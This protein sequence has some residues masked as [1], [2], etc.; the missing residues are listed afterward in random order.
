MDNLL[1]YKLIDGGV[2]APKGFLAS[3]I[4]SGLKK[5]KKDLALIYSTVPA[6]ASG[7]FTKN[8]VKAA[9][10][11]VTMEHLY[12]SKARAII[13]NSANAN[14]CT[15]KDGILKAKTM[16]ILQGNELNLQAED[17]LVS[18]TGIIG[19]TLEIDTIKKA[20]PTLTK[21]LKIDGSNDAAKAIL[22]TDKYTKEL[23]FE[24]KI[25]NSVIKIG[26]I[27]KGSGMVHPNMGTI[28]SFI[29][30]DV[31]IDSK[32]LDDALKSSTKISYNRISVD[33]DTST[34]DMVLILANGLANNK[35]IKEKNADYY[36]F[37]EALNYLNITLS[38]MIAKDGDGATKLIECTVLGG[39][40][41]ESSEILAKKIINSQ[42]IKASL[43]GNNI[44]LGTII[45]VLGVEILDIIIESNNASVS[46]LDRENLYIKELL[47]SNTIK[48][49]IIL[50]DNPISVTV[51]GCDLS[52]EYIRV[53]GDYRNLKGGK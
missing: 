20:I 37:L 45:S 33:G 22:T 2:T 21:S 51:W 4:H 9:P 28:L 42:I 30:T 14:T 52:L 32:L 24:F 39:E 19:K 29:T 18:S 46:L 15:G 27:A 49:K 1:E 6:T 13:C 35:P 11:Y 36:V 48:I 10:I 47:K 25:H 43:F 44:N 34:N 40:T 53:T 7:V 41:E 31:A 23:S 5:K 38:K 17:I 3:G 8:V 26:A 16:A 50:S 12:N